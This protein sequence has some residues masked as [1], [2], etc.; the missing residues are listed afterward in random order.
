[1]YSRVVVWRVHVADQPIRGAESGEFIRTDLGH[2]ERRGERTYLQPTSFDGLSNSRACSS[3]VA[4]DQGF[5]P[6]LASDPR[7]VGRVGPSHEFGQETIGEKRQVTR[8]HDHSIT[9]RHF[10]GGIDATDGAKARLSIRIDRQTQVCEAGGVGRDR[11]D[12]V[13]D[14]LQDVQLSDDD[15]PSLDDE[16]T[17]VLAAESA[18]LP[19][20]QDGC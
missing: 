16:A 9:L 14:P 5:H 2:R 20:C 10:Q 19:A 1:L 11:E 8:N 6:A 15:G 13:S 17:L 3:S 7:P 12:F 4:R 18:G